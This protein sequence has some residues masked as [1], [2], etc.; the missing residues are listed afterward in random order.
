MSI[1]TLLNK[2]NFQSEGISSTKCYH[3]SHQVEMGQAQAWL[4]LMIVRAGLYVIV[5]IPF[6]HKSRV[7]D[8][9]K[10]I[11]GVWHGWIS[12]LT[13]S[14]IRTLRVH[15]TVYQLQETWWVMHRT[16]TLG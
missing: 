11:E 1:K 13:V 5:I 12:P 2:P 15:D 7:G 8:C 16:F 6:M 4:W 3:P 9:H 14:N 10:R